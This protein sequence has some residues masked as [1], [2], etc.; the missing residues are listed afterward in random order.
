MHSR[1]QPEG[2]VPSGLALAYAVTAEI[3]GIIFD[4][5]GARHG[6]ARGHSADTARLGHRCVPGPRMCACDPFLCVRPEQ[7]GEPMAWIAGASA[8]D[9]EKIVAAIRSTMAAALQ[10]E[11]FA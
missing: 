7:V 1:H 9:G 5:P 10:K 11:G 8:A 3:A 6:S 2:L 4:N